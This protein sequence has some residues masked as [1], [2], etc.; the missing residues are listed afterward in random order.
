MK[1]KLVASCI[2]A[3][4][5]GTATMSFGAG[6]KIAEQGAKAM[7]MANA[8][9]AQADDASALAYNPAGIAFQ[10]GTQ[11]QIGSTTI[12]VPETEFT[13]TTKLSGTASVTEEANRDIFIAPTV[14]AT[15]SLEGL[16][17][18]FGLGINS[19][20]PLA[21]RWDAGGAFRDN[22][23]E[24]SIKPINFQPTVAYRLDGLKLALAVGVDITYAQVSLQKMPY[25]QINPTTYR[26][27]GT[28]GADANGLGYGYN[29]GLLWKPLSNLSFG[30]AYRSQVK[31]YLDGNANFVATSA[32]GQALFGTSKIKTS[33]STEITLP[34]ALSIGVAW[35]PIE[36]LTLEF[37]TERTG[38]SSYKSFEMKFGPALASF[39]NKPEAKNWKDVW[40]YRVGAQYAVTPKMDMRAGYAYDTNPIPGDTLSP[41]LPDADRHN[42]SLGSGLHNDLGSIDMSYM[43]V[44]WKDR[45][46]S[47]TKQVGTFKSTA[48]LFAVAVTYKF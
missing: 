39:N 27:L 22:P 12:L 31:L 34:D 23:Y 36:K 18:S 14:Y 10:K 43:L 1:N 30:V 29:L 35:K 9:A 44:A 32:T 28:L 5:L 3:A 42:F 4:V 15:T 16:P 17:L 8:F 24:I 45:N 21:K 20:H 41:E 2:T 11:L 47:N 40:A 46:V 6:F 19:F 26:E 33:G 38:W 25:L 13:G 7:G 37:D 48:H